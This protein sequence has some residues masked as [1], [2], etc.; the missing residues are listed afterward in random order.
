MN[1]KSDFVD[2]KDL[3]DEID[4]I[5]IQIQQLFEKRMDVVK[6]VAAYKKEHHLPVLHTNRENEVLEK[7]A[8]RSRAEYTES[9]RALFTNMMD[10]SKCSQTQLIQN[11][12]CYLDQ[13]IPFSPEKAVR[14]ACQ[15]VP[16]AYSHIA[17]KKLFDDKK[18]HF[19]PQFDDVF[20]AVVNDEADYGV[21]PVENSNAG[22]VVGVYELL[23]KYNIYIA[24]RLS[25]KIDHCL[26]ALPNTAL[27]EVKE[28]YSHEQAIQQC[29]G[30]LEESG[31]TVHTYSNTAA[32]AELVASSKPE[33]CL[34]VI[35][36]KLAAERN[37]LSVIKE[38]IANIAENYTRFIVISK[39]PCY[40]SE[41][42][43]ISVSFSLPHTAG[44]LYRMLT[45]FFVYNINME[46]IESKPIGNKNFDAMFYIDFRGNL[47]D[48]NVSVLLNDLSTDLID[49]KYLGNYQEI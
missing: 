42:D 26:A 14:V 6:S 2:L 36:S 25:I 32:S 9:N 13:S 22:S 29:S 33:E 19:Y 48:H 49:F 8:D 44:S 40:T 20:R 4:T 43:I 17:A 11:H 10:I 35:C 38:E 23:K 37:G 28:V 1:R 30:F 7:V 41:A 47:K 5:D 15:G 12:N 24:K 34:A 21:L 3:R 39:T 18:L 31:V 27:S 16:G 46:K 45:K